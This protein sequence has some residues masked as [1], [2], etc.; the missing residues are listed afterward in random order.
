MSITA[1]E[2][3]VRFF[4]VLEEVAMKKKLPEDKI[5]LRIKRDIESALCL[6]DECL[7]GAIEKFVETK[8]Q[9]EIGR[10]IYFF[11]THLTL[12]MEKVLQRLIGTK[13]P[14]LLRRLWRMKLKKDSIFEKKLRKRKL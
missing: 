9:K 4:S 5:M 14:D 1:R 6:M 11:N 3:M 8:S 2:E 7:L 13:N 10:L 12:K